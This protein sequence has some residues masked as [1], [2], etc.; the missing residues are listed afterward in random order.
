VG[1]INAVVVR[2]LSAVVTVSPAATNALCDGS[3]TLT[4]TGAGIPPLS[5]QWYDN[6]TNLIA[7]ATSTN[8]VLTNLQSAAGGSYTVVVTNAYGAGTNSGSVNVVDFPTIVT[9]PLSQTNSV[10]SN[11]TF[12]VSATACTALSYQW[13]FGASLLTNDTNASLT[14]TVTTNSAGSYY[15]QVSS[16][17]GTTNSQTVVLTVPASQPPA[18]PVLVAGKTL[19]NKTFQLTFNGASNETYQVLSS[20]N[21]TIHLTNWVVLTSGTFSGAQTNY[22]DTTATNYGARY[23]RVVSP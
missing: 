3:V 16:G 20:T 10:G 9:Q 18:P 11:V 19:A 12:T 22:T 6:N 4:A 23:Y 14:F 15:V 1:T 21:V 5:Y 17:G 8:L 7:G 2:A 13:Y